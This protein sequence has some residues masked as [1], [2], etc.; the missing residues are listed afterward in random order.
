MAAAWSDETRPES[1][2]GATVSMNVD[3][4]SGAVAT[5]LV[6]RARVVRR[7]GTLC[8]GEVE[9]TSADGEAIARGSVIHGYG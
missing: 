7:G 5:D 4:L 2:R 3:Y 8:F 1:L 9:V 6:A